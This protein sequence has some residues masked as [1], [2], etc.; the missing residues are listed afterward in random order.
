MRSLLK[1]LF[2]CGACALGVAAAT[3]S[4]EVQGGPTKSRAYNNTCDF[5]T[6]T[7]TSPGFYDDQGRY[8]PVD[9]QLL[10][11]TVQFLNCQPNFNY[12][13]G[14]DTAADPQRCRGMA[15]LA[16]PGKNE[17]LVNCW[18]F[19]QVCDTVYLH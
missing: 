4:R 19:F 14:Y 3:W 5:S 18:A 9:C 15:N 6:C 17:I 16:P 8:T 1:V 2:A 12:D 11:Q 13:C 7:L 10:E